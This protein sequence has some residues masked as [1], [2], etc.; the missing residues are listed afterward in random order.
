MTT[1]TRRPL[2]AD[3]LQFFFFPTSDGYGVLLERS[4]YE[5]LVRF[6][7]ARNS[8]RTWGDVLEMLGPNATKFVLMFTQCDE[9]VPEAGDSIDS[10]MGDVWVLYTEEFP[11][12]Q[13][14]EESFSFYGDCFPEEGALVASTDYDEEFRYFHESNFLRLKQHLEREGHTLEVADPD[15]IRFRAKV[16][17][18]TCRKPDE[19]Q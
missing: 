14:A 15:R 2:T 19:N 9:R 6:E 13:C 5:L 1:V 4:Y 17:T 16:A 18:S 3:S 7:H 11:F 12:V 8:A 10:L